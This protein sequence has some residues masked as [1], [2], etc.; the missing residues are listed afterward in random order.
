MADP[1][2]DEN[3]ILA[4]L[5]WPRDEI[6]VPVLENAAMCALLDLYDRKVTRDA[7]IAMASPCV[8]LYAS[9]ARL[10]TLASIQEVF[11]AGVLD[12]SS[13]DTSVRRLKGTIDGQR[14]QVSDIVTQLKLCPT[15]ADPVH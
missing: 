10:D 1:V 5:R 3:L 7:F 6:D 14:G 12:K 11:D 2:L 15:S 4:R 13:F 8:A 9:L